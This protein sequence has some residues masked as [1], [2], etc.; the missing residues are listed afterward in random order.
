MIRRTLP[1]A[2]ALTA[3]LTGCGS[4]P[5]PA[6]APPPTK[7]AAP[8]PLLIRG[9]FSLELPKFIWSEETHTCAGMGGYDDIAGG[10]QV[11]VTDPAGVNLAVGALDDGQPVIDPDDDSRATS[12]LFEFEVPNVP[13]GKG[14]YGIEVGR[15][16]KVQYK[17][18]DLGE[19]LSLSLG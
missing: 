15:R 7:S 14:I 18:A 6:A 13:S 2:L 1:A 16:G 4:N 11:L 8:L 19:K 5:E 9:T 3:A 12:C 10:T 17:E